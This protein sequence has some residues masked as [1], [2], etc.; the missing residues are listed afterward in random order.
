MLTE[1]IGFIKVIGLSDGNWTEVLECDA[2]CAALKLTNKQNDEF[3]CKK[4]G[5][6]SL[7]DEHIGS[8]D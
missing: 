3:N 7:E 5:E 1:N 2:C 4:Y 8:W 6:P